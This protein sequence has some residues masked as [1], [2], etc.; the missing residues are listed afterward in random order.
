M[1]YKEVA[2]LKESVC[3]GEIFF[4]SAEEKRQSISIIVEKGL[5]KKPSFFR[6]IWTMFQVIGFR[7]LFFGMGDSIFL[8]VLCTIF[9]LCASVV[10]AGTYQNLTVIFLFLFSPLLY[11]MVQVMVSWKEWLAGVYEQKMAYRY[12]LHQVN[13]L[14]MLVFGGISVFLCIGVSIVF[15]VAEKNVVLFLRILGIAFTSLFLYAVLELFIRWHCKKLLGSFFAPV[16]WGILGIIMLS[17]RYYV[18]FYLIELPVVVFWGLAAVGAIVYARMLYGWY[19]L[20][21]EG[22]VSYVVN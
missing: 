18:A 12:T 6:E 5:V 9:I 20:Q 21:R 10:L 22:A 4:P 3:S 19:F 13:T 11:E 1:E 7:G 17:A 16:L 2:F 14:R 8:A 15:S